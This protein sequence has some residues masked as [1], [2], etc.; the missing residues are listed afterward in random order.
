MRAVLVVLLAFAAWDADAAPVVVAVASSA[1]A[2]WAATAIGLTGFAALAVKAG[3]GFVVSSVLNKAI[4]GSG[5]GKQ[6]SQPTFQAEAR[7]RLQVVRSAVETRRIVYGQTMVSGPL[8]YAESTTL[9][10]SND[11][12]HL[13]IPLAGHEVEEIG[14]TYFNDTLV[15]FATSGEGV[16]DGVTS[17]VYTGLAAQVRHLGGAGQVADHVLVGRSAGKWTAAHRLRGIAYVY[18]RLVFSADAYPTGIPNLKFLVKGKKLYDPRTG[19]TVWSDNWALAVRDYLTAD[20]GLACSAAEI[21]DTS[22]I[23]AANV[24]DENVSLASGTQK[25]YTVNGTVNLADRPLDILRA[26]MS[27]GAGSLVYSQGKWRL[28]AGA[29][30]SPV[31]DMDEDW[32]AGGIQVQARVPR[33]DLYNAVRGTFSDP[34]KFWQPTDFPAVVNATYEAQDGDQQIARDI[35]LPFTTDAIRAQR[36]AKIHLERSRQGIGVVMTCNLK[37]FKL[38]VWDTVRLSIDRLGWENKVFR[39]TKWSF[40]PAGTVDLTLAEEASAVYDWAFGN[41]TTYD[42]A[43]DTNLPDPFTVA[44]PGTPQVAEALYETTGSAGVKAR[45]TVSWVA[46]V[47]AFAYELEFKP[48][49]LSTWQRVAP[50]TSLSQDLED[51]AP[52]LYNF[53]VRAV[54]GFGVHS[55]WSPTVTKELLGLTAAP[56]DV[57]G[58]YVTVHE[59]RAR[60]HCDKTT[61]LDVAIGGRLWVRWSPLTTD[62]EW[63]D[64]SLIKAEGYPGDSIVVEGPLYP[65]T[66]MAKFQDSTGNFSAAEASFVVTEALLTGFN[67]LATVTFHPAFDGTKVNT[68][69]IDN[70][71]QLTGS[72]DWDD[73][74]GDMDDW[75]RLDSLGGIASSGSCTFSTKMD[76]AVGSPSGPETVRLVPHV[77]TL[78]FDTGDLW[79]SRTDLMDTWG[80]IDGSVIEDAEIQP[81]VRVTQDDPADGGAEWGPWHNLEVADYTARGFEFRTLHTSANVTHNRRLIEFSV[82]A[83]QPA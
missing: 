14:D 75:D 64:G 40:N 1:I 49:A 32:L 65:G 71:L 55:A 79:D 42:A 41:A 13:V 3:I 72:T 53:R 23:A 50:I 24:A 35:E 81:Q 78:G 9:D 22:F 37:A 68:A 47:G 43:P 15:P 12:L 31:A 51:L 67:T 39:V 77:K 8:V 5:S 36:I 21:D 45:A 6:Q 48:A 54:S 70:M 18:V 34:D 20:Y 25:R 30:T 16:E 44:V 58:F 74:P 83:K 63:N 17:G 61:D 28:F 4:G 46:S 60:C 62:A 33:R 11:Q 76:V 66:Y 56:A 59:G 57:A 80:L 10:A 19:L 82:A 38:A 29:Y 2:G 27:A 69:A 26:L 7:D 52:G 73:I